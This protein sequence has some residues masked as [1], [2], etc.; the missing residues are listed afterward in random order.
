MPCSRSRSSPSTAPGRV[1]R[2]RPEQRRDRPKLASGA[3]PPS[4]KPPDWL[5]PAW[6]SMGA[7]G[8]QAEP[9]HQ[10]RKVIDR[11]EGIARRYHEIESEMAR[12]EVASE[13]GRASCRERV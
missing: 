6:A 11:L 1:R 12:P 9:G 5:Q 10:E 3:G 7:G 8:G 2:T 4:G 13:I